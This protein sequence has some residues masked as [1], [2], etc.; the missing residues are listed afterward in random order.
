MLESPD[1]RRAGA[2]LPEARTE[3]FRLESVILTR[4]L[5]TDL[6]P[7]LALLIACNLPTIG[8]A[9]NLDG[10]LTLRDR[11][12]IIG[13]ICLEDCGPDAF[14]RS[15][16]VD[17]NLRSQGLGSM[18][19][20]TFFE[21]AR[22]LGK[23]RIYL[24]TDTAS[25]FFERFGFGY[26]PHD[27]IPAMIK[28]T[29]E[30]SLP[31]AIGAD[32]MVMNLRDETITAKRGPRYMTAPREVYDPQEIEPLWQRRWR[33][34]DVY[35][36]P[37]PTPGRKDTYVFPCS[38]F[39]SGNVHMG[40][41]RS[42]TI[43]DA[44]ARYRRAQGDCVLFSLGYDAFGLPNEIAA[45]K[46]QMT[47]QSWVEKCRD[48][49]TTQF[50]RLGLSFD[51][52][53]TFLSSEPVSYRW[54]QWIFL[55]MYEKGL[56]YQ[57]DGKVDWCDDCQTVLARLQAKNDRCWR[58]DKPVRLIRRTQW[59]LRIT[60]YL[61]ELERG[62]AT[63]G[64]WDRALIDG[65]R[66]MLGR[67]E[68][69]EIELQLPDGRPIV[70]FTRQPSA[71]GSAAFVVVSPQHPEIASLA[72]DPAIRDSIDALRTSGLTRSDRGEEVALVATGV[73]LRLPGV[74]REL[75]VVVSP[76]VDSAIG[77]PALLGVPAVDETHAVMARRLGLVVP[78]STA[79][80]PAS[81]VRPVAGFRYRD[82]V[83]S[84]QRCWGAPIPIIYC[85]ACGVVPVP[86]ADL[87]VRLPDDLMPSGEGNALASHPTFTSAVCPRCN[88][89]ARRE[90][91]TL[92][93]HMDALWMYLPHCVP[94]AERS[95]ALFNH[96]EVRRWTPVHQVHCGTDL[97]GYM[98]NFRFFTKALRDCGYLTH[99][100]E[101]EP[102]VNMLMHDMIVFGGRKMSKHLGNVV[103]PDQLVKQYGADAVRM[104]TLY[105]A[106]PRTGFTWSD[107]PVIQCHGFITA[108]W[109][110]FVKRAAELREERIGKGEIDTSDP[111]RRR[112]LSC[113]Q[114]AQKKLERS[115][116][117]Q[118][119]HLVVK[120]LIM[121]FE[122]L[123]QFEEDVR[124]RRGELNP[125]DRQARALV[126]GAVL[127]YMAP[128]APHVS[129][130]LWASCGGEGMLAAGAWPCASAASSP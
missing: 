8:V 123:E 54:T 58:C 32:A 128:L 114:A 16:A 31:R 41:V 56:V 60:A 94:P 118:Q 40:H 104:G 99:L 30:F 51:W 77:L 62:L 49:M 98:M 17:A 71:V 108:V 65:Q 4:A 52:S 37:L 125:L 112:L 119:F 106:N 7:I 127:L 84:R 35:R 45:I 101:G 113:Y 20:T 6:E 116:E 105:A 59:Y 26:V 73:M 80:V 126:A 67:M 82:F 12:S 14:L 87:P 122:R 19:V 2:A 79:A 25:G 44:Y 124:R 75:P 86:D 100:P 21:R 85:P 103:D 90:T 9:E 91:D 93:C 89:A 27:E 39:A 66:S 3:A 74:A 46:H 13:V 23:K 34:A 61:E 33:E 47:P 111:F 11:D 130:E 107:G 95:S 63:I 18:L 110:Y 42:Y 1:D 92:D 96:P 28:T 55:R 83:I 10:F 70:V 81:A 68:G 15:L 76:F 36:T 97:V 72:P 53:R 88:G 115:F 109:H 64:G 117:D 120:N 78:P 22:S 29:R 38:P 24:L 50:E 5:Q 57:A 69:A 121:L 102:I 129:E 43:S 48:R